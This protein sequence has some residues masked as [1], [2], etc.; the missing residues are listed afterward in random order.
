MTFLLGARESAGQDTHKLG[1]FCV[2]ETSVDW[3]GDDEI[4]LKLFLSGREISKFPADRPHWDADSDDLEYFPMRPMPFLDGLQFEVRELEDVV[5]DDVGRAVI[6]PTPRPGSG[7]RPQLA[8][9]REAPAGQRGQRDI[10]TLVQ[11]CTQRCR[12]IAHGKRVTRFHTPAPRPIQG[13][14]SRPHLTG[15]ERRDLASEVRAVQAARHIGSL[16]HDWGIPGPPRPGSV[17][18]EGRVMAVDGCF[19]GHVR[20]LSTPA[21]NSVVPHREE[22][23]A[24]A[25]VTPWRGMEHEMSFTPLT[26][27]RADRALPLAGADDHVGPDLLRSPEDEATLGLGRLRVRVRP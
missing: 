7:R 13:A 24:G 18:S 27:L 22:S 6:E 1:L 2:D 9:N 3:W 12:R 25:V 19:V 10:R 15:P 14:A 4:V 16:G 21:G 26:T 5:S 23:V 8:G 11:P 20:T 17:D